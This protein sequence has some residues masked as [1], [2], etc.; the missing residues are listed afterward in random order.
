M[1]T[2][3]VN[4]AG[5][6]IRVKSSDIKS[7]V[8]SRDKTALEFDLK[9]RLY[10]DIDDQVI[11]SSRII[12][13]RI[14]N[15]EGE[16]F[17]AQG[18]TAPWTALGQNVKL[19]DAD[20]TKNDGSYDAG[21]LLWNHFAQSSP[22]GIST[23]KI[24][25]ILHAMRPDFYPILDSRLLTLYKDSARE[26]GQKLNAIRNSNLMYWAAIR[27]DLMGSSDAITE[28]RT[29]LIRDDNALVKKWGNHVSDLRIHDVIAWTSAKS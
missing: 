10:P 2:Y 11:K 19:A 18:K 5:S 15:Q 6:P 13:S 24:S 17:I 29:D 21:L 8:T 26:M 3:E 27:E 20:P 7:Y 4:L 25:K 23:A 1:G 16:W 12:R 28:L 9:T 14:S 22:K